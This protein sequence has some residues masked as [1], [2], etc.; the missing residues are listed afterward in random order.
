MEGE[1]MTEQ[2]EKPHATMSDVVAMKG[3]EQKLSFRI[4]SCSNG[5]FIV[6]FDGGHCAAKSS[7]AEVMEFVSDV[8][9]EVMGGPHPTMPMPRVARGGHPPPPPS[10]YGRP[11]SD[12]YTSEDTDDGRPYETSGLLPGLGL[13][14]HRAVHACTAIGLSLLAFVGLS[15]A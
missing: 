9:A 12:G 10:G 2:V 4:L 5:G 1:V 7:F 8:G 11:S 13:K 15:V 6:I 14:L 3:I